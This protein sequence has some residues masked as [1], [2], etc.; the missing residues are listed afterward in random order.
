M[1]MC[2]QVSRLSKILGLKHKQFFE[3]IQVTA[4]HFCEYLKQSS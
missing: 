1:T 3:K 4:A 2:T